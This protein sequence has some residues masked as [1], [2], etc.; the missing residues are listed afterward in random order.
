MWIDVW[1]P[2]EPIEKVSPVNIVHSRVTNNL[3]A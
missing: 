3:F 2:S 1:N